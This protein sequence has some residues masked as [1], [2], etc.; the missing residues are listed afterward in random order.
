M[1]GQGE[2][3]E[4]ALTHHDKNLEKLS[5]RSEERGIKVNEGK[6]KYR[7]SEGCYAGHILSNMGVRADPKK[8]EAI[9]DMPPP[10]DVAGVRRFLV[11]ANYLGK[12]LKDMAGTCKP[13]RQLTRQ[14][15]QLEWS[16]EQATAFDKIKK[17]IASTLIL[18]YFDP[19]TAI[20]VQCDASQQAL[21]AALMQD[22]H[23]VEFASRSLTDTEKSYAQI[24]KELL[25]VVFS[26]ENFDHC[27]YGQR[28]TVETDHKLLLP[29]MKKAILQAAKRLQ[30]M[31]LQLQRYD[32]SQIYRR[33]T[34]MHVAA[35]L[36]RAAIQ[37]SQEEQSS[38]Q[39]EL[40]M[41]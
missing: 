30:R 19:K 40:E 25:A 41:I 26:L 6:F 8:T 11:M 5:Q 39:R 28:V 9:C 1:F 29:I 23:V 27:V 18:V 35:T 3:E 14:D 31:L 22:D 4:E 10:E 38:F 24:E 12:F 15:V 7:L 33:G 34:D 32:I 20:E 36:S 37:A 17:K 21:G 2:T 16:H 13:L